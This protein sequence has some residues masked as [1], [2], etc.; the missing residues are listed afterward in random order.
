MGF[1]DYLKRFYEK[2]VPPSREELQHRRDRSLIDKFHSR[3]CELVYCEERGFRYLKH[4]PPEVI[5]AIRREND[6]FSMSHFGRPIYE[7]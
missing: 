5:E 4:I 2:F 6:R 3:K 1:R 7:D